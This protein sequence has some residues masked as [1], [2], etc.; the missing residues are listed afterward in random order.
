[1][2]TLHMVFVMYDMYF[3]VIQHAISLDYANIFSWLVCL[4]SSSR[5][6]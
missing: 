5:F 2:D 6:H 1:M 4:R 3:F